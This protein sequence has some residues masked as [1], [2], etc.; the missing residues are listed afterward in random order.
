ME[1]NK[2]LS[3]NKNL[4]ICPH[5]AVKVGGR[6]KKCP[7]CQTPLKGEGT[8]DYW[9]RAKGLQSQSLIFRILFFI[10]YACM[11]A[12]FGTKFLILD[13]PYSSVVNIMLVILLVV[14]TTVWIFWKTRPGVAGSVFIIMICITLVI[15][16][17][18]YLMD[19]NSVTLNLVLPCIIGAALVLNFIITMLR[20]SISRDSLIYLIINILL[21]IVPYAALLFLG[22]SELRVPWT[23]T[24]LISIVTLLGLL[25]FKR[26]AFLTELQKRLHT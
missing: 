7:L 5:C 13:Y 12:S 4:K 23:I 18:D 26:S 24:L 16:L 19:W 17:L 11:I 10:L 2:E 22:R 6:L 14:L 20:S 8:P 1:E 15:S 3:E 9:P 21:G 25:I